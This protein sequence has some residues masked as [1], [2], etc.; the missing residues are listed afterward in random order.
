MA[1]RIVR[2][3]PFADRD[4][5]SNFGRV[6]WW[7]QKHDKSHSHLSKQAAIAFWTELANEFGAATAK[8]RLEAEI[9]VGNIPD[10]LNGK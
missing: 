10:W 2:V 9:G 7:I 6:V 4:W 8:E 5:N 3:D 1:D